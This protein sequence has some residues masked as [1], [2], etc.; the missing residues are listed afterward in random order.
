MIVAAAMWVRQSTL[1]FLHSIAAPDTT[2]LCNTEEREGIGPSWKTRSDRGTITTVL[3][4]NLTQAEWK[5]H[6]SFGKYLEFYLE[7]AVS[8]AAAQ[9]VDVGSS[10]VKVPR[11]TQINCEMCPPNRPG[12]H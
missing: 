5:V 10:T 1:S 9:T 12:I 11:H 6:L 2:V 4:V 3:R 8:L 7:R